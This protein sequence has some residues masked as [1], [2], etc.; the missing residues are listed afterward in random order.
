MVT[1]AIVAKT[2]TKGSDDKRSPAITITIAQKNNKNND[3]TVNKNHKGNSN[4]KTTKTTLTD[5]QKPC[6]NHATT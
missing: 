1:K 2:M 6:N 4:Q 5:Q 3:K